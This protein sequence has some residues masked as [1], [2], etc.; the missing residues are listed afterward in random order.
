M[1]GTFAADF[2]RVATHPPSRL[3]SLSIRSPFAPDGATPK[4]FKMIDYGFH[5]V[6]VDVLRAIS[7]SQEL[8]LDKLSLGCGYSPGYRIPTAPIALNILLLL[9]SRTPIFA[10]LDELSLGNVDHG[11]SSI[12]IGTIIPIMNWGHVLAI[13]PKLKDL[14]YNGRG[15]MFPGIFSIGSNLRGHPALQRLVLGDLELTED[16]LVE[17]L[18]ICHAT[19][20][21][22]CLADIRL[23][24]GTWRKVFRYLREYLYLQFVELIDLEQAE[25]YVSLEPIIRLRPTVV[26]LENMKG[27]GPWEDALLAMQPPPMAEADDEAARSKELEELLADDWV[28]VVHNTRGLRIVLLDDEEGDDVDKWLSVIETQHELI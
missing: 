12:H 9:T 19:L 17:G 16:V 22:L 6:A 3:K 1:R 20:T 8:R 23:A 15:S 25:L 26:D 13:A 14:V 21:I 27:F 5:K 7:S 11:Q 10:E 24:I 2:A 4:T 28:L 18:E